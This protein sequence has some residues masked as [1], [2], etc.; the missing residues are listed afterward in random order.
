[1]RA[2]ADRWKSQAGA[3][4]SRLRNWKPPQA[5]PAPAEEMD[6]SD[7]AVLAKAPTGPA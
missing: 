7:A 1:M 6:A 3:M 5:E 4:V 2:Q